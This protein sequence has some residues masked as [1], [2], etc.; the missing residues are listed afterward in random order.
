MAG[1]LRPA[2]EVRVLRLG[3]ARWLGLPAEATAEL[4]LAWK[5]GRAAGSA[6]LSN[7]AGWLRYLPHPDRF[8]APHGHHHYEVLTS[9]LEPVAAERLLAAGAALASAGA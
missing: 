7:V 8:R 3:D 5:S 6:L 4:G 1:G 9:T 2:V